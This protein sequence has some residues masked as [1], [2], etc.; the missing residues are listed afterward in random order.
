MGDI[1]RAFGK[2][3]RQLSGEVPHTNDLQYNP[4]GSYTSGISSKTVKRRAKLWVWA[5]L[6]VIIAICVVLGVGM[7]YFMKR[8]AAQWR[9]S[10]A[11]RLKDRALMMLTER[12][13]QPTSVDAIRSDLG[14][15]NDDVWASVKAKIRENGGRATTDMLEAVLDASVA[16]YACQRT[17]RVGQ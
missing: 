2:L 3:R 5:H 8:K 10:Q 1:Q 11:C 14:G 6:H 4:G 13:P 16:E 17:C 9:D 12:Y 15:A 7:K